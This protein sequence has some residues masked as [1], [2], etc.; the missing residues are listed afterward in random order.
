ASGGVRSLPLR[1]GGHLPELGQVFVIEMT[2][3]RGGDRSARGVV[4]EGPV[5]AAWASRMRI[6]RCEVRRWRGGVI[7]DVAEAVDSPQRVTEDPGPVQRLWD[8]V[9][10]RPRLVWGRDELGAGEVGNSNSV[11][12]WLVARN[13]LDAESIPPPDGG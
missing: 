11:I 2:P 5:G 8:A 6:F 1:A 10:T 13:G 12:S 4:A 9:P 3:V 7:P